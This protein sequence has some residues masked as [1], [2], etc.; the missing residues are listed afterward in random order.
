MQIQM[1]NTTQLM[2]PYATLLLFVLSLFATLG[3]SGQGQLQ[4][5]LKVVEKLIEQGNYRQ[6]VV[7][8]EQTYRNG[9]QAGDA[10]VMAMALILEAKSLAA[11]PPYLSKKKLNKAL[12]SKIEEAYRLAK[13]AG[14]EAVITSVNEYSVRLLGRLPNSLD[15]PG[16][17]P[18]G[19]TSFKPS[20]PNLK[21]TEEVLSKELNALKTEKANLEKRYRSEVSQLNLEQAQQQLL[22]VLQRQALD[23][24]SMARLQDSLI[25][26]KANKE[27]QRQESQLEQQR[28]RMILLL[29]GAIG[30]V[31]IAG[32][33]TWLYFNSR[34][35][36]RIIE[37][38][39][40]RSEALLLNILPAEVAAE[41]KAN[42]KAE[43]RLYEKAT[44]LFTDFKN[45]SHTASMLSPK[46]LVSALDR[47]FRAFDE[48]AERHGLEKIKTIGDA[49]M[50]AGGLP[51][52]DDKHPVRCVQAALEMQAWLQSAGTPFQGARIGMH[53]GAVIAGV[54]GAKKFAY[55][56]WGDAVNIAARIEANGETGQVNLSHATYELVKDEFEC[57][58]RG[59]V[60]AKNI[61]EVDM[62]FVKALS[63]RPLSKVQT[64][65]QS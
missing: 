27:L 39:R 20:L 24:I 6:A 30:I 47:C 18:G 36:N 11:D 40:Q 50:C 64:E 29:V 15:P 23:S 41:L 45:F 1:A 42:G 10:G 4:M 65:E 57:T 33:L 22:L 9:Q 60:P 28:N 56:I 13:N 61:G 34:R 58:H 59:K 51:A 46:K 52:T 7:A 54:V 44:V 43:A 2:N 3:L 31:L 35:K 8:A 32:I 26:T 55:D 21:A 25:V 53:T 63:A 17:S 5:Q 48:I 12:E 16:I 49:Y 37:Q 62:Y 38:E 14:E 19:V